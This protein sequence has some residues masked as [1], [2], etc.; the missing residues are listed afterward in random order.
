MTPQVR[1]DL[2]AIVENWRRLSRLAPA[3][4]TSAVVKANAYGLGVER[5]APA[6]LKAGCNSFFVANVDEALEL[7]ALLGSEPRI[8]QLNG[9]SKH[10]VSALKQAGVIPVI[11][12]Q[13]QLE[14][15]KDTNSPAVLHFDTGMN[16][17]GLRV[18]ELA[19]IKT[20]I[21]NFQIDCVM[22]HLACAD[23]PD[24]LMNAAQLKTFQSILNAFP[25]LP[26]SLANSAGVCLG[27]D[28]H[29]NL[30]RPGIGL[31]G[32]FYAD[33]FRPEPVARMTAPL[34]N[35]FTVPDNDPPIAQ[36]TIGYG[37][38]TH[39]VAGQR[40]G[41]IACG[42]ADGLHRAISNRGFAIVGGKPAPII[43]KVSMDLIA[44]DLT[45]LPDTVI[46]G[47]HVE[48]FGEERHIADQA[49]QAGTISYEL[50]TSLGP[51]VVRTYEEPRN[52]DGT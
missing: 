25:E 6:L 39:V 51:R 45:M 11:N 5:I 1:I 43:G 36:G 40:I 31:Y 44:L 8:F 32:G 3:A 48:L 27:T 46:P 24:H 20:A 22:S 14:F 38:S 42:Y 12:A 10:S 28:Y 9:P 50:L 15:W 23:E 7:R 47:N 2:G 26:A 35:V 19:D 49:Q 33:M 29:F 37:A 41:I 30:T 16:R 52:G 18:S 13:H 21:S 4:E 34:I 17:L